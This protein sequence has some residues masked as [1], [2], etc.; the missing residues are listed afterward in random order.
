MFL[1]MIGNKRREKYFVPCFSRK[2]R[3]KEGKNICSYFFKDFLRTEDFFT[4]F[5]PSRICLPPLRAGIS[6]QRM[7]QANGMRPVFQAGAGLFAAR[8]LRSQR[9]SAILGRHRMS[10]AQRNIS[11]RNVRLQQFRLE[12]N[13]QSVLHRDADSSPRNQNRGGFRHSPTPSNST[14][15]ASSSWSS[16]ISD[17]TSP[18]SDAGI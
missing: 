15:S 11:S 6:R 12:Q 18:S 7:L 3:E 2:I 4:D 16:V 9:L 1:K 13:L 8:A 17:G 5:P 10:P 14:L